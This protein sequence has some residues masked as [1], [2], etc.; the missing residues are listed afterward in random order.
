MDRPDSLRPLEEVEKEWDADPTL[1]AAYT[2]EVPYA[3]VAQAIIALRVRHGLSQSE[4]ARRVGKPQPYIARLE[5]GRANVQV[6]TL[7]AFAEALGE[8]LHL[9]Y[10]E[11]AAAAS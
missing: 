5:S 9:H 6:G 3:E 2:R 8:R 7:Q 10:G 11:E 1:R 4:F